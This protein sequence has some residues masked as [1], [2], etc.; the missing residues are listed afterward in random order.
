MNKLWVV[1][2]ILIITVVFIY[3]LLKVSDENTCSWVRS[4]NCERENNNT[5]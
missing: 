5:I 4:F 1:L 2:S 3:T